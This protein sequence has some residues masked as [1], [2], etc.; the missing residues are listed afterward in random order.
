MA[1]IELVIKIDEE[2]Y[3]KIK[4][5]TSFMPWAEHLIKNGTPLNDVFDKIRA[6]IAELKPHSH[7][8]QEMKDKVLEIIDKY[9]KEGE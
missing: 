6:E 1:D 9:T 5:C 2:E 3:K 4:V 8:T 7:Y